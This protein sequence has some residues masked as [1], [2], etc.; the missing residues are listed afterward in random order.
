MN[1]EHGIT[2]Y[3]VTEPLKRIPVCVLHFEI[4]NSVL[5]IHYSSDLPP[6]PGSQAEQPVRLEIFQPRAT[7][8]VSEARQ[9]IKPR[10]GERTITPL[11]GLFM[12]EVTISQGVALG[13]GILAFQ[14]KRRGSC[15]A[16]GNGRNRYGGP[17][18]QG[19]ICRVCHIWGSSKTNHKMLENLLTT[20]DNHRLAWHN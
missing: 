12:I 17:G 19:S 1:N 6:F 10:R 14:A 13:Y 7:P 15:P 5:D 18:F 11:Q 9:N 2:N 20:V 8:W 4:Q 16:T 3:E